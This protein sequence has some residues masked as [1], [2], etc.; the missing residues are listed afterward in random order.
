MISKVCKH[1]LLIFFLD[2]ASETSF[3][4]GLN[5]NS[6]KSEAAVNQYML[7]EAKHSVNGLGVQISSNIIINL[8]MMI[9]S[10]QQTPMLCQI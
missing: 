6:A 8:M 9:C 3:D 1:H 10:Y 4:S 7:C 2:L 5:R